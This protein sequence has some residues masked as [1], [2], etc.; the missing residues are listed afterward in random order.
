[1]G[2]PPV[3][4]SIVVSKY[5]AR[6]SGQ[7]AFNAP[8]HCDAVLARMNPPGAVVFRR[9]DRHHGARDP[10]TRGDRRSADALAD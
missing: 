3:G 10:G 9:R 6:D 4:E 5:I 8:L 2:W 1:V 7:V